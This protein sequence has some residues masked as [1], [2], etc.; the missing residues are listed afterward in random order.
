MKRFKGRSWNQA[1]SRVRKAW[2]VL[3]GLALDLLRVGANQVGDLSAID[4]S[5]ITTGISDQGGDSPGITLVS[6][7]FK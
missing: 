4:M 1:K 6:P 2:A 5:G 7:C 3:K